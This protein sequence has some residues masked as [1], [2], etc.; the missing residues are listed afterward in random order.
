MTDCPAVK[1]SFVHQI[2]S[3]VI[4]QPTVVF[5]ELFLCDS[6]IAGRTGKLCAESCLK[7]PLKAIQSQVITLRVYH[8]ISK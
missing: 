6:T 4:Y 5:S 2:A 8:H 3:R 1:C 7:A